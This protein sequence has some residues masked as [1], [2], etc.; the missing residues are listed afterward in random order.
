[1]DED[2]VPNDEDHRIAGEEPLG[3]GSI[4]AQGGD[5]GSESGMEFLPDSGEFPRD[6]LENVLGGFDSL[7]ER[8]H[9]VSELEP[10]GPDLEL[11]EGGG[12]GEPEV[13]V[14]VHDLVV[15]KEGEEGAAGPFSVELEAVEEVEE[16]ELVGAAV[17]DVAELDGDGVSSGPTEGASVDDSGEGEGLEG[18]VEV[19]VE[20]A[21]GEEAG[22]GGV[23]G[24]GRRSRR[25][26]LGEEEAGDGEV[27]EGV[28]E[29]GDIERDLFAEI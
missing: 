5:P 11:A 7:A 14:H 24:L 26:V 12:G 2:G 9:G 1:M 21:D 8:F 17:E 4:A 13:A 25:R 15:S 10:L 23:A 22:R 19:S 28:D 20:V 16:L 3:D 27:D 6:S 18:L 29:G